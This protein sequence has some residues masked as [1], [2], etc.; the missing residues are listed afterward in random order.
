MPLEI[1][2]KLSSNGI[3]PPKHLLPPLQIESMFADFIDFTA[4][5]LSEIKDISKEDLIRK[6]TDNFTL[7]QKMSSQPKVEIWQ[8]DFQGAYSVSRKDICLKVSKNS[9]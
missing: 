3:F 8:M 5:K 1:P 2:P 4:T 6:T 9:R 7:L